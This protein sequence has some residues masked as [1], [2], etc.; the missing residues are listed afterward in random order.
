MNIQRFGLPV[1]IAASLHGALFLISKE[2][3]IIRGPET[4]LVSID[5]PPRPEESL[6]MEPDEPAESEPGPVSQCQLAPPSLP[7]VLQDGTSRDAFTVPVTPYRPTPE[8]V[9][10][11]A[12][13][14]GFTDGTLG[15][16]GLVGRP[17]IPGVDKLDRVPRAVAQ[18]APVYPDLMRREGVNGT[19]TVAFIVDTEGRV[20]SAHVAHSTHRAFEDS[21]VRAVLRWRFEPGTQHGRKVSFRMAVPIEF[22]A[23]R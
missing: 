20:V 12:R 2:P 9:S 11:L 18:P 10:N 13:F 22:N 5:L 6:T 14:T 16:D 15:G 23:A 21:A 8:R 19:V 3:E 4:K 17:S 7:D 1:I